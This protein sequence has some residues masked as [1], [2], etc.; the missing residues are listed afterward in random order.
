MF[1]N[2]DFIGND[3][4]VIENLVNNLI[5]EL[6]QTLFTSGTLRVIFYEDEYPRFSKGTYIRIKI[7][8]NKM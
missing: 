6:D 8:K 5:V 7:S 3:K 1:L 2:N 4:A